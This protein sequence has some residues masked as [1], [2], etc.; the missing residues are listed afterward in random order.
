MSKAAAAGLSTQQIVQAL[1]QQVKAIELTPRTDIDRVSSGIPELDRILPDRGFARGSLVEWLSPGAGSGASSLALR[2]ALLACRTGQAI[3]VDQQQTFYLP[4]AVS[5]GIDP[6]RLVIV[7]PNSDAEEAWAIDQI[8]RCR[9]VG[10]LLCWPRR[11][12]DHTYRRWQLAAE[13]GSTLGFL[14]RD[15]TARWQPSWAELRLLV[16]PVPIFRQ[17]RDHYGDTEDTERTLTNPQISQMNTDEERELTSSS[18]HL[19]SSVSS[20]SVEISSSPCPPRL[21]GSHSP[22]SHP[23]L[24]D[25]AHLPY[26]Q[27]LVRRLHVQVLR[28]RWGKAGRSADVMLG[29]EP[30]SINR[31]GIKP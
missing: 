10:A 11:S 9:A 22:G 12:D 5:W 3:V 21:R 26:E 23:S 18:L 19:C 24:S 13:E 8:L 16:E 17:R 31:G 30:V 15:V 14:L 2:S 7:R 27:T 4:G 1:I 28:C 20:S 6:A 29:G 25:E